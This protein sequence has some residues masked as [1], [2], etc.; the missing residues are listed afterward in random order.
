[1]KGV[2][3]GSEAPEISLKTPSDSLV[4]LSSMRGKYVLIDFWASWCVA[5]SS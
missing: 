5:L 3:I 1:M 2:A 4:T